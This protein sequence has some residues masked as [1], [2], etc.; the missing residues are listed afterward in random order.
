VRT[1]TFTEFR[2]QASELVTEVEHGQTLIVIRHGR[3]V[4]EISPY[5]GETLRTPAWK[6]P[7]LRLKVPGSELSAAIL[8]ERA[9]GT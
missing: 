8:E 4:V 2:R 9:R 6:Q 5:T 7:G 3:P 1:V